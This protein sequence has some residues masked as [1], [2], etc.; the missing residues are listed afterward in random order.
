MGKTVGLEIIFKNHA[1]ESPL[2]D[3]AVAVTIWPVF[4]EHP[5]AEA[6]AEAEFVAVQLDDHAGVGQWFAVRAGELHGHVRLADFLNPVE[7]CLA[8]WRVRLAAGIGFLG[9]RELC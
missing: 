3:V 7:R 1:A 4:G 2:C 5:A 9:L 6:G 8:P